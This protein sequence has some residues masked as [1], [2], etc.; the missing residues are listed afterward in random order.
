MAEASPQAAADCREH[1]VSL[2]G[3]DAPYNAVNTNNTRLWETLR[4]HK[5]GKAN[6]HWL[7]DNRWLNS[8]IMGVV[9]L[10]V[11][12]LGLSMDIRDTPWS[13]VWEVSEY[14]F[15][16][17]FFME[18]CVK[19]GVL[20]RKYFTDRWNCLDFGLA[21]LAVADAILLAT[22]ASHNSDSLNK[23][24]I[25]RML[26]LTRI[27][28]MLRVFRVFKELVIIMDVMLES[29]KTLRW[30][31]VLVALLVYVTAIL[32]VEL[33]G[34]DESYP[35]YTTKLDS[36]RI[37]GVDVFNNYIYFGTTLRSMFSLFSLMTLSEWSII[38]RPLYEKSPEIVSI[39]VIFTVITAYG[40]MNVIIGVMVEQA[41]LATRRFEAAKE[42]Q[43]KEA[44]MEAVMT[45]AG[46]LA[47]FATAGGGNGALSAD[48]LQKAVDTN[49]ALA[50]MLLKVDLHKNCTIHE[51][52]ILI[53]D[54]GD[55]EITQHEFESA[56][57]RLLHCTDFQRMCLIQ[58]GLNHVKH[59]LH[60][61]SHDV[62]KMR[63]HYVMIAPSDGPLNRTNSVSDAADSGVMGALGNL[64]QELREMRAEFN[65]KLAM[66][67]PR[68]CQDMSKTVASSEEFQKD[69]ANLT[70]IPGKLVGSMPSHKP[71]LGG[72]APASE[73]SNLLQQLEN[74]VGVLESSE[75]ELGTLQAEADSEVRGHTAVRAQCSELA[76]R[77]SRELGSSSGGQ[78]G[79]GVSSKDSG[80]TRRRS[81]EMNTWDTRENCVPMQSAWS[82][83]TQPIVPT[84]RAASASGRPWQEMERL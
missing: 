7:V 5:D 33:V 65:A 42:D 30:L 1:M 36:D 49:E 68:R 70:V 14:M 26:R 6:A 77:L 84:R 38:T 12:Q 69:T 44:Q 43:Y 47:D 58:T 11:A 59:T 73:L 78:L 52:F 62:Q 29:M 8:F 82:M 17:V 31:V 28:R 81:R 13:R 66:I 34:T 19:I 40:M 48:D 76:A 55:G 74:M 64:Q 10:N 56:M 67:Q 24:T 61:L 41:L 80:G 16:V 75:Q 39:L 72:M 51:L 63:E 23:V 27:L 15:A 54:D 53:D 37:V 21:W 45:V 3:R 79:T 50:N 83:C 18:M 9:M 46:M 35:S 71:R 60:K 22:R 25:L 4:R 20:G 32:C 57:Y 2:E